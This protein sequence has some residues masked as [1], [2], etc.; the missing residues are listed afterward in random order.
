[1]QNRIDQTFASLRATKK[2]GF[3]AYITGGDPTLERTVEVALSLADAG[4]DFLEI[5]VFGGVRASDAPRF[6]SRR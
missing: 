1:M 5:G 2:P 3:M 4:V 6:V